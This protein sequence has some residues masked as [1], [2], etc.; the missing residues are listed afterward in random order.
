M[1]RIYTKV[2]S[3]ALKCVVV[4]SEHASR[5]AS[6]DGRGMVRRPAAM[7]AM[8]SLLAVAMPSFAVELA[9]GDRLPQASVPGVDARHPK[10]MR[11]STDAPAAGKDASDGDNAEIEFAEGTGWTPTTLFPAM[12]MSMASGGMMMPSAII[13]PPPPTG[14]TLPG[15]T[16]YLAN[17]LLGNDY[18]ACGLAGID[19]LTIDRAN[20]N[21]SFL[22]T[23]LGQV[24][25]PTADLDGNQPGNHLTL[26]GSVQ[27][28]SYIQ[29]Q[30]SNYIGNNNNAD[31]AVVGLPC[32]WRTNA[33]Q[34][35]QVIIGDGSYANGSNTV[36]LGTNA[37]HQLPTITADE[38]G[39]T[40]GPDADYASRLGDSVVI[41]ANGFGTADS[42]VVIGA[43]AISNHANSV[44][45]GAGSVTDVGAQ[46]DY[47]AFGLAALQTSV[48]EVSFGSA[49]GARKLTNVAAG[50]SGTDAVNVEQLQGALAGIGVVDD[51]FKVNSV[52]PVAQAVGTD[53]T[54]IGPNAIANGAGGIA[55]GLNSQNLNDGGIVIGRGAISGNAADLT[56]VNT[57]AIGNNAQATAQNSTALGDAAIASGPQATALGSAAQATGSNSVA[58]GRNSRAGNSG[59]ALGATAQA[60]GTRSTA[61]G[62]GAQANVADATALGQFARATATNSVAIGLGSIADRAGTVSVGIAGAERQVTNVAAGTAATDAVNVS[63]LDAVSAQV[64]D[65][66][67]FAVKYDDDGTGN[68][69]T[70]RITLAGAGG[71]TIGNLAAGEVSAT[72]SEAINGAQLFGASESVATALGGGVAVNPDGSLT[73]PAYTID[74]QSYDNV[75]DAF[76]AVDGIAAD[77]GEL[78]AFAVKYDDDGTGN[79]DTSRVTLAGAGGTTI[80][81]LAPGAVNAASTEAINGGQLYAVSG[82]VATAL[83][84]GVVVGPDGTLSAPAFTIGGSTYDSVGDAFDAVD[85]A[86]ADA[87]QAGAF[88]VR[89]DDDGA[90]NP[91]T[92]RVT[93]EGT[94]G[95]TIGNVAAGVAADEAVNVGQ[96]EPVVDALGGGAAIDPATGAVTG[97]TYTLDDGSN[98]GT[99]TNYGN[100]G[101]ALSNLDGR[102]VD[103]TAA[104][105]DL[106]NNSGFGLVRQDAASGVIAIGSET[107]G[108]EVSLANE[109]G[110][111]RLL[112]GVAAGTEDTDALNVGQLRDAGVIDADG[113]VLAVA[114][115]SAGRDR[116]TLAGADGTVVDNVAAGAV[117]ATSAEAVNGSQ[118]FG[119]GNDVATAFGGGASFSGGNFVSPTYVIQGASYTNVGAA[120]DAVNGQITNLYDT[121]AGI[122]ATPG[123]QGPEGP[124]G[125]EGP[126]G[127][128]G[129]AGPDG[130]Q[131]PEGPE[132]PGGGG[133][134]AVAYDDD[135]GGVL[136]LKGENGT[137]VG[138]V[139]NGVAA[140][141]AVN[142]GQMDAGDAST[143]AAANTY[144]DT[145]ATQTLTQANAYTDQRFDALNDRFDGIEDRFHDQ[146]RRIDRIGAM[147]GALTGMAMNSTNLRGPNRMA[148]GVGSQG[149]SQAWAVGYQRAIRDDASVSIGAAFS[150]SESTLSAGAGFSW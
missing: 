31:C 87:G 12:A 91:D 19:C 128:G 73:A 133:P 74:G 50:S 70:S 84:A 66:D 14:D 79:P 22:S 32:T 7:L 144:T 49:T 33:A 125:P 2:W 58:V 37:R 56:R 149:G 20:F 93:L 131:G 141:D 129:P 135:G 105:E 62:Q 35:N 102:V 118:L 112:S 26:I 30:D 57:V 104:I 60:N 90:G 148:V 81:N 110:T 121:I 107:A 71:T 52:G 82:S 27:S 1:N 25:V 10:A 132:G 68:P 116:I 94:A 18:Q 11:E 53:S 140:T 134:R 46:A 85:G 15:H 21:Y 130:P 3:R 51:Y 36:V 108:D 99:T 83:G 24:Q 136:T 6:G 48:G 100:V 67:A 59:T 89:Y 97:P 41:G 8:L 113:E 34:N 119:V 23:D 28:D 47:T 137:R 115:D 126:Q 72:S 77:V 127:P 45:L 145:T 55:M 43:G 143:L 124:T 9:G 78:D 16:Q 5:R 54:A 86:L 92:S 106:A 147:S 4:A 138:N 65:V 17:W 95:T 98:S 61:L 122:E 88:A 39:F 96:L 75:G 63:Q 117:T 101:D 38:A 103:N 114:Y 120:F 109:D 29:F 40:G 150:G 123:P 139:A 42:Q 111:A 64:A 146:D 80:G 69:D 13:Q 44:A 142:K 76:T